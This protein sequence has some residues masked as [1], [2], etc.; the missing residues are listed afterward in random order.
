MDDLATASSTLIHIDVHDV[1]QDGSGPTAE[2]WNSHSR[3]PALRDA[4]H[5]GFGF[6]PGLEIARVEPT[7]PVCPRCR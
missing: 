2:H 1:Y 6:Y 4:L 7:P 3:A 5:R